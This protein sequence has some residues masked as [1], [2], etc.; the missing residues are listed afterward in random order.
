MVRMAY[1][2]ELHL[3]VGHATVTFMETT[4]E[5]E[6]MVT[7]ETCDAVVPEDEARSHPEAGWTCDACDAAEM[8]YWSR[9]CR[10]IA[11]ATPESIRRDME[12]FAPGDDE[13]LKLATLLN[14]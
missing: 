1:G 9:Q 12:G 5:E 7:C 2:D 13:Y 14:R 4:T 11:P 8:E 6:M 3:A 10:G